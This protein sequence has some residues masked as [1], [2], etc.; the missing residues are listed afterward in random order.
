M[1]HVERM[2]TLF[3][4]TIA[5][6]LVSGGCGALIAPPAGAFVS[7]LGFE[8]NLVTIWISASVGVFFAVGVPSMAKELQGVWK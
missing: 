6:L 2:L 1:K 5:T 8:A 4:L 3:G 7:L